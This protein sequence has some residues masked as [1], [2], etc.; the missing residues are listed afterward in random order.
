MPLKTIR[1]ALARTHEFPQGAADRGYEF[2]APLTD[3]GH[4]DQAAWQSS[5][6]Q[7][8]VRRFWAG[9]ADE[10]GRLIH[11][12]G[13]WAFHYDGLEAPEDEPI[14][15]FDQHRFVEGEYVTITEYD[16][17]A[18]PFKVVRVV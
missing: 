4:L 5:M 17:E 6:E 18:R 11:R 16:G 15:K 10:H 8:T 12:N 7:C 3:D 2:T 9:E 14:F 1:L 13:R